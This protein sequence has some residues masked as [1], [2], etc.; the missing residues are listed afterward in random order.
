MERGAAYERSLI[1]KRYWKLYHDGRKN[2]GSFMRGF[3]ECQLRSDLMMSTYMYSISS[4]M[5]IIAVKPCYEPIQT[6][7]QYLAHTMHCT[8]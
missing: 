3:T 6:D 2:I 4:N 7:P 5:G 8:F 1:R